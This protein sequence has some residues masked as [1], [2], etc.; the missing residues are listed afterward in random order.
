MREIARTMKLHGDDIDYIAM[1]TGL[2][3]EEID[4]L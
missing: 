4:S 3:Q 1:V 2:F